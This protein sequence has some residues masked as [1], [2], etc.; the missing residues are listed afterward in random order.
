MA[1]LI[2]RGTRAGTLRQIRHVTPVAPR[3]A[4]GL[5]AEVYHQVERD[6]GMLAPPVSL[7]SP[8]PRALAAA[9]VM[10]RETLL[11][12]DTT[13]RAEREAVAAAV[14]AANACPYCVDVHGAAL[15]GLTRDEMPA[16]SAWARSSAT[17]DP[18]P[19]PFGD[20]AAAELIGV[21]VAFHYLNRMVTIFLPE[22]PLPPF[23]RGAAAPTAKRVASRL[24]GS[25]ARRTV[26]PGLSAGL[27]PAA[28]L[29]ADLSWAAGNPAVAAAFGAAVRA[30]DQTFLP[31]GVRRMARAKAA[32]LGGGDPGWATSD[33]LA[34]AVAPLPEVDRPAGRLVLLTMFAPYR[35]TPK[36]IA[37][38]RDGRPSDAALIEVTAW[39]ALLAARH[40]GA[41]LYAA[42]ARGAT[43]TSTPL[44]MTTERTSP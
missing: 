43:T 14:S 39:A 4:R 29:P 11:A 19:A 25:L 31:P 20:G 3:S 26:T 22:S 42:S 41:R 24:L 18:L 28:P 9:W 5:V 10:L 44:P 40:L 13:G 17:A 21:A 30:V 2:A 35:V 7:H 1:D 27:L 12:A 33:W 38:F 36:V 15:A 37:E 23:L 6:F 8:A 34:A 16:L 32:E